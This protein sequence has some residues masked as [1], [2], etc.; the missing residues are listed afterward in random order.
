MRISNLE[1]LIKHSHWLIAL[2][3]LCFFS[4]GSRAETD[5]ASAA[6]AAIKQ[7]RADAILSN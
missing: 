1:S 7:N 6:P 2:A 3:L 4:A 5:A